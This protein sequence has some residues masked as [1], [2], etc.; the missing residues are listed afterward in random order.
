LAAQQTPPTKEAPKK[1]ALYKMPYTRKI[2]ISIGFVALG[3][4]LSPLANIP[5]GP[6]R[7]YP[8]QHMINILAAVML[9]PLYAAVIAT[10]IGIL[11]NMIG[12]GTFFAFPGGIPG[13]IVVG[14]LYW[15]IRKTDWMA[16]TESIG[17]VCIGA[18][19]GYFIA[20]PLTAK[21]LILG[22]ISIGPPIPFTVGGT[23]IIPP[24]M[25]ALWVSFAVS[26][27]PGSIVGFIVLKALRRAG[28]VTT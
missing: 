14:L 24:G 3:V 5:I 17:T 11:R 21:Q 7:A 28:I 20:A 12:T 19:I 22:F 27:V 15:Y 10:I 18:T 23:V 25:L 16:F 26:C 4:A 2:A 8:F 6:I 13:G 9:G 1:P